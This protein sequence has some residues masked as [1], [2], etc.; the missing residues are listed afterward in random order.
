MPP[1]QRHLQTPS[2]AQ[3]GTPNFGTF[4]SHPFM[5]V[6]CEQSTIKHLLYTSK[7]PFLSTERACVVFSSFEIHSRKKMTW[8]EV[9]QVLWTRGSMIDGVH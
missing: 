9:L 8:S 2:S 6:T 4:F 1:C 5:I 3:T 7:V